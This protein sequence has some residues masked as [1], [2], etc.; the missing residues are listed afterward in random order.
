MQLTPDEARLI[1]VAA[2]GLHLVDPPA[3]TSAAVLGRLGCVQIDSVSAVRRSHELV[4]LSR[5]V[6]VAEVQRLGTAAGPGGSFEG[7][8]HALSLMPLDLWPAFGFRRRRILQLGWRGPTVDMAAVEEARARLEATG[9]VRLR[10]FGGSTGT[11]W[12]RDS[13][14]RWALEW[15]AATGAAVCAERDGWERVYSLPRLVIPETLR[16]AELS[17]DACIRELCRRAVDALGVATT[18]DVA[19][20]FRLRPVEA[21]TALEALGLERGTVSGWRE[22]VWLS[23]HADPAEKIDEETVTPLSPFDSLVWTR[24]RLLRLFGKDYRL[25]AYKPAAK[26]TFGYFS[27]P[28]LRGCDIVGRVALR[29]RRQTLVVENTEL[30]DGL[31]RSTIERAVDTVADWTSCGTVTYE[32]DPRG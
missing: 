27:L 28:V 11:G 7:M 29:R 10:D 14:H 30:D 25:E 13:A 17:D 20:Y 2:Q 31:A 3:R 1:A 6:Q 15:L 18:K 12:E 19:D 26:R 4:L 32:E 5:G 22:P 21:R 23:P 9:R 24:D 16:S 8:G